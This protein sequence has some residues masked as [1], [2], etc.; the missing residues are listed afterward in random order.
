[1]FILKI[2]VINTILI[3]NKKMAS[4]IE[5]LNKKWRKKPTIKIRINIK[6]MNQKLTFFHSNIFRK[7]STNILN[8]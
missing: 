2:S 6:Q 5:D 4:R 1:M 3:F 7:I 8:I